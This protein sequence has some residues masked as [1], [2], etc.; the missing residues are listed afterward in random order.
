[1]RNDQ[2][3][4]FQELVGH[5]NAFAEQSAGILPQ[6]K[7]QALAAA[8]LVERIGY[9]M[10]GGFLEPCDWNVAH[11]RLNQETEIAAVAR[12]LVRDQAEPHRLFPGF[13]KVLISNRSALRSLV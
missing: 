9:L 2:L 7:H 4:L 6:V 11:A 13:P 10:L 8:E 1:M 3:A 12:N 5:A